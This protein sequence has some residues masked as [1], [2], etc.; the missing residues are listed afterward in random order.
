[1]TIW[2][3]M[4]MYHKCVGIGNIAPR[5]RGILRELGENSL[6]KEITIYVLCPDDA[7]AQRKCKEVYRVLTE[8][9]VP[10]AREGFEELNGPA[11]FWIKSE[12]VLIRFV[13]YTEDEGIAFGPMDEE[14]VY[15][16]DSAFPEYLPI[17]E[18]R[19]EQKK[20]KKSPVIYLYPRY[21]TAWGVQMSMVV[22][23]L[24]AAT[25]ATLAWLWVW[26]F[27]MTH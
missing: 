13:R 14:I 23:A 3:Y 11:G 12:N 5:I 27:N 4:R 18:R 9:A 6:G 15:W 26:I 20:H 21:T 16:F 7:Y 17:L 22:A 19:V 8:S 24:A 1:M 2:A 25:A 10:E